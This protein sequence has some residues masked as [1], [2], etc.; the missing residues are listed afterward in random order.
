MKTS[1]RHFLKITSATLA[2]PMIISRCALAQDGVPGANER[3]GVAGIGVGRQGSFVFRNTVKLP[4]AQA[5]CTADVYLPRAAAVAKSVNLDPENAYQDYRR[6]LE[7]KD[8]DAVI[9]ATPEHWRS[10]TCIHAAQ[11]GKHI[12]SEKPMSLTVSEGRL[13]VQAARKYKITFQTGS[14]QRSQRANAIGCKF[15]REGGLGSIKEVL[16]ANYESPWLAAM[17]ESPIPNG[18]DWDMWCGPTEK[19][20]YNGQI[21]TPRGNPGWLSLRPYSG[22]EMTGWGTHG[23]DQIQWALGMQE[24]GPVEIIVTGEKLVPPVYNEPESSKRG[25]SL[26]NSPRLAFRYANGITVLLGDPKTGKQSNRG[27]AIFFGSQGKMEIFRGRIGTNPPEIAKT[28]LDESPIKEQNHYENWLN[29][30]KS[31]ETP[32]SDVEFGHRTASLCHILNIARYIGHS[33]KWDPVAERFDD[34]QANEMLSRKH[35]AGYELPAE[36]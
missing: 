12:Y 28:L 3:I 35:R 27:G 7:R 26:C 1:R 10:L 25:N 15:I 6:V 22:G 19:V 33:L 18:L 23:L 8:V 9:S 17:P 13:M 16:A 32:I 36:I 29:C 2:A 20:P 31:G 24:T 4:Q 5:I 21:F 34:E 30:I 11:A 14:Q